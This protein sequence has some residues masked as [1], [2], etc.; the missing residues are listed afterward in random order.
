MF[1]EVLIFQTR[2]GKKWSQHFTG[3]L[4]SN[5]IEK[6][7]SYFISSQKWLLK[8]NTLQKMIDYRFM[9]VNVSQS[10]IHMLFLYF[11]RFVVWFLQHL[12]SIF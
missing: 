4:V 2:K 7:Y 12:E 11:A 6:H 9:E 3:L 8:H 5:S 10:A 1:P